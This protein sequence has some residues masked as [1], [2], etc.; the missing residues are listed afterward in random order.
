MKHEV[1]QSAGGVDASISRLWD[2]EQK[3]RESALYCQDVAFTR[4]ALRHVNIVDIKLFE[5]VIAAK[6]MF[7]LKRRLLN[8]RILTFCAVFA[9]R[10]VVANIVDFVTPPSIVEHFAGSVY[11][12]MPFYVRVADVSVFESLRED[13]FGLI[14]PQRDK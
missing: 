2:R 1:V 14:A 8:V 7:E 9:C 13:N 11:S 6:Y 12:Q 3:S 5:G 10:D 4:F